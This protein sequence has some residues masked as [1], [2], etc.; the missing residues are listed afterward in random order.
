M[1]QIYKGGILKCQKKK[2]TQKQKK[3]Q[4]TTEAIQIKKSQDKCKS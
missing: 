4:N 2:K 3:Q 1:Y